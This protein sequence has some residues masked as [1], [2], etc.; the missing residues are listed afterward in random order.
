MKEAY[1]LDEIDIK[2]SLYFCESIFPE[3]FSDFKM[4]LDNIYLD[5]RTVA[6][7]W[8]IIYYK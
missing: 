8:S 2:V 1:D 7:F 6:G 4:F 3:F 5:K